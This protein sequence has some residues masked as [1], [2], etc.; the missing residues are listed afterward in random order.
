MR[1]QAERKEAANMCAGRGKHGRMFRE[2]KEV[3]N[4][5]RTQV[6]GNGSRWRTEGRSEHAEVVCQEMG[7]G[8]TMKRVWRW[9][10]HQGTPIN[11]KAGGE[12]IRHKSATWAAGACLCADVRRVGV[13]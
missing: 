6:C 5:R 8:R 7:E 4:E 3:Q 12:E 2:V 9:E 13:A 10:E 11:S 1:A